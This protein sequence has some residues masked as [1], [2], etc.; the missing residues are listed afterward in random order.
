VVEARP[1]HLQVAL[2]LLDLKPGRNLTFQGDPKVP[3]GSPLEVWVEWKTPAG[4]KRF[5]AEELLRNRV[6][7]Q[8][9]PA[10]HW[11]F[12]GSRFIS[13]KFAAGVEQS[14]VSVCHDPGAII[15]IPLKEAGAKPGR[16]IPPADAPY[17]GQHSHA[18]EIY[19]GKVPRKGTDVI[20]SFRTLPPEKSPDRLK[21]S[22]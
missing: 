1:I 20:L 9:L 4:K 5:R 13:G 7:R 11:I 16:D 17:G 15:D 18:F 22:P 21:P 10:T 6:T 8:P 12:L 2:L 14:L 19:P 3:A